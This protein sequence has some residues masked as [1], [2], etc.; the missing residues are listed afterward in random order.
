MLQQGLI[1]Q[2]PIHEGPKTLVSGVVAQDETP[3]TVRR[4][5]WHLMRKVVCSHHYFERK[6]RWES[7][8]FSQI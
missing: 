2:I 7:L 8:S 4:R 6:D 3:L 1:G 5:I